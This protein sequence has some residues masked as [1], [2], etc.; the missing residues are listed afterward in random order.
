MIN[1]D[2][3]TDLVKHLKR[4]IDVQLDYDGDED[5]CYAVENLV[6]DLTLQSRIDK[7]M[8]RPVPTAVKLRSRLARICEIAQKIIDS[9]YTESDR[10][11]LIEKLRV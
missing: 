5:L 1:K 10:A 3:E 4:V 11:V 7:A 8:G 9:Q 6:R 2:T